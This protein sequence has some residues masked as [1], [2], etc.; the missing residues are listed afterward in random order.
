MTLAAMSDYIYW[1]QLL[2][3]GAAAILWLVVGHRLVHWGLTRYTQLPRAKVKASTCL[4]ISVL[5]TGA[6]LFAFAIITGT[7]FLVSW[8]INSIAVAIIGAL[9]GLIMMLAITW[10]ISSMLVSVPAGSLLRVT[11]V[12]SGLFGVIALGI[13]LGIYF[14]AIAWRET[15]ALRGKRLEYLADIGMALRAY[16]RKHHGRQASSIKDLIDSG[17]IGNPPDTDAGSSGSISSYI[18]AP[19]NNLGPTNADQM[20]EKIWVCHF[21]SPTQEWLILHRNGRLTIAKE[22]QFRRMLAKPENSRLANLLAHRAAE[23]K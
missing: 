6:G 3:V 8:R 19:T 9:G 10:A 16:P 2:L 22:K 13:G 5:G 7:F 20:Q 14:P 4:K 12:A 11:L 1:W 23:G 17:L 15:K 18:Y 21:F